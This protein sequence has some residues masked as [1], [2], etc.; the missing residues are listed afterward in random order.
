MLIINKFL[1]RHNPTIL[2]P[3]SGR[4]KIPWLLRRGKVPKQLEPMKRIGE[5]SK[6][7]VLNVLGESGWSS[8]FLMDPKEVVS[9]QFVY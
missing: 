1:T 5:V 9:L 4:D 2:R 6:T 8:R 3:N 7:S